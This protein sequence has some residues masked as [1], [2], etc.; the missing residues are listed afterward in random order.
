MIT[1]MGLHE[2][3]CTST[4]LCAPSIKQVTAQTDRSTGVRQQE[5]TAK[6]AEHSLANDSIRQVQSGL[7]CSDKVVFILR[8]M[9]LA[10]DEAGNWHK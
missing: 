4:K 7:M 8:D 2:H 5:V 3:H 1:E 6:P 10:R 9:S